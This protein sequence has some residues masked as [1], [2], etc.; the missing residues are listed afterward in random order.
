MDIEILIVCVCFGV[1]FLAIA[2]VYL[3]KY[4]RKT[5]QIEQV[6]EVNEIA[7]KKFAKQNFV[8]EKYIYLADANTAKSKRYQKKF[9]AFNMTQKKIGLVDY[10]NDDVAVVNFSDLIDFEVY[11]N[12]MTSVVGANVGEQFSV[13][14][15]Q[16]EVKCK[17]LRLNITLKSYSKSNISYDLVWNTF[18]NIGINKKSKTYRIMMRSLQNCVSFLKIIKDENNKTESKKRLEN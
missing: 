17:E 4:I 14:T 2:I 12:N 18:A 13:F 6:F 11:E 15:G 9:I 7:Q 3:G 1:I 8:T 10:E 16:Q 5:Q